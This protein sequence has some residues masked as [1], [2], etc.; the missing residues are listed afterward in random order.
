M[1]SVSGQLERAVTVDFENT[2]HGRSAQVPGQ[3]GPNVRS[4]FA[5]P[6]PQILEFEALCDLG[7]S[8]PAVFPELSSRTLERTPETA[9]AFPSFPNCDC[10]AHAK[11]VMLLK[12]AFLPKTAFSK[13]LLRTPS[14]NPYQKPS[15]L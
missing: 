7:K 10:R 14:K 9:T 1:N 5:F 15:S 8:F 3:C 6:V 12:G 11:G 2:L 4:T 13:S